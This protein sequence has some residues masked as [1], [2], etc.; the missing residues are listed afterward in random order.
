[1]TSFRTTLL[2]LEMHSYTIVMYLVFLTLLMAIYMINFLWTL[3]S[4]WSIYDDV[5]W[6]PVSKWITFNEGE[7]LK[8]IL[9]WE[10]G[11]ACCIHPNPNVIIHHGPRGGACVLFCSA[12]WCPNGEREREL[13]QSWIIRPP[14]FSLIFLSQRKFW[15]EGRNIDFATLHKAVAFP[16][17]HSP[18]I[19]KLTRIG[20]CTTHRHKF[21]PEKLRE[22]RLLVLA[23]PPLTAKVRFIQPL[24]EKYAL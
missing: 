2:F 10:D 14:L 1:M 6:A 8:E 3:L 21:L 7:T 4:T 9:S 5:N 23:S 22:S 16:H 11:V 19:T 20:W 13:R 18:H 12:W 24:G 15:G 17:S